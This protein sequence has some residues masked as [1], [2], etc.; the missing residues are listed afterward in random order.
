MSNQ[1]VAT[2][3]TTSSMVWLRRAALVLGASLLVGLAAHIVLPLPFTPVPLSMAPFAVMMLGLV[4][5][6]RMAAASLIAYLVEGAAGLPFFSPTGPGGL[7]HLAWPTAGY[8]LA[9]PAAAFVTA[10]LYR[11]SGRTF[12][13]AL[14]AAT[15]GSLLMIAI[16]A[17]WL[18]MLLHLGFTATLSAG[19]LP[20]LLP[21]AIKVI[22][23]STA[24]QAWKRVRK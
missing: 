1:S 19:V 15:L 8:L 3:S 17:T 10:A 18:S 21:D 14:I 13:G 7:A 11:R 22:V 24:V 16:G 2:V 4:L 23:A 5:S 12:A 20:F 6:P 9:F